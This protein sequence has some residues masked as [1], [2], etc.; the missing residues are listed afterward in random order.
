[1]KSRFLLFSFFSILLSGLLLTNLSAKPTGLKDEQSRIAVLEAKVAALQ[2]LLENANRITDPHTGQDTLQ[3]KGVNVQIVSGANATF[4]TPD[5]TGNLIIGYNEIRD[6]GTD[7]RS[8]SHMLVLGYENN[9]LSY[10]GI[11]GGASNTASGESASAIGGVANTA[12]GSGSIVVGGAQ[13]TASAAGSS[14]GGG[15]N[16]TA[17]GDDSTVSGGIAKTSKTFGCTSAGE[18]GTDC[19]P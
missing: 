16:N 6:D 14:V 10:G 3:F 8:G 15:S 18:I 17:S 1:M 9:Y 4:G 5:G 11:V 19:A 2:A 12:S 7:D 13:N